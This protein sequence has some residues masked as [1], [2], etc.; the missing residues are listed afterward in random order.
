[1]RL[2]V[3]GVIRRNGK[4]LLVENKHGEWMFPGGKP[5]PE[6]L[7]KGT[8]HSDELYINCLRKKIHDKLSGIE[9]KD[10]TPHSDIICFD[11][12]SFLKVKLFIARIKDETKEIRPSGEIKSAEWVTPAE[13][14][15]KKL[16]SVTRRVIDA[17]VSEGQLK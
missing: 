9:L 10:A 4:V 14:Y 15:D 12:A 6:E 3:Q 8:P 11:G 5:H 7:L 16:K 1:M 17:L 2:V 13:A